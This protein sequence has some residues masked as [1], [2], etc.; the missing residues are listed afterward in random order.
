MKKY[1]ICAGLTLL[2]TILMVSAN[3]Q[4]SNWRAYD[5][6]G[7]NVFEPKKEKTDFQEL[8]VRVGGSFTQQYQS[9][10]HENNADENIVDGKNLNQLYALGPGFNLATANLY[11]DA[12]LEDGIR[13]AVENYMSSRHH[14]EFWVKGG[15]V[16]IDALPMFGNTS[17][18]DDNFRVKLGH[19]QVNYGDQQFR[20]TD[21]GN[22]IYN[23]F[24]GNTIMDA[25]A[26]EIGGEVYLF[27][28]NTDLMLMAGAT[29]GLIAGDVSEVTAVKRS[30]SMYLK[31]AFDRQVN[32]DLRFRLSGSMYTNPESTRNTLYAGDRGGSRFYMAMEPAFSIPRGASAPAPSSAGSNFTS[33]RW[34]P[35]FSR[36]VT[37]IMVNPFVKFKGLE[38]FG[39]FEMASGYQGG[40][41]D[42]K[43]DVTQVSAE[44]LYRF[45]KNEQLYVGGRYNTL[46]GEISPGLSDAS[47]DRIELTAGWYPIQNMLLKVAYIDQQ[48]KDFPS[49]SLFAEGQFSG[50]MIEAVL[51]F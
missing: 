6:R 28:P 47:I 4:I 43:R 24:V 48:Y 44:L 26:T 10:S 20:R 13:V 22:A 30:P 33:G 27:V 31:A 5:Q 12:Q 18:F 35:G 2:L 16:Q 50:V 40:E 36:N 14:Q 38:F 45:L 1:K 19:F 41:N 15:Y 51:G 39:T 17:W 21:N 34:N 25:F 49:S 37:A 11:I 9:L 46:S 3:A 23:P 7:V 29:S 42:V 32:D 8:K